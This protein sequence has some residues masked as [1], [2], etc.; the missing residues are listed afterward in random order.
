MFSLVYSAGYGL[1]RYVGVGKVLEGLFHLEFR[2]IG[3]KQNRFILL[4]TIIPLQSVPTP[5]PRGRST[6]PGP[7][8]PEIRR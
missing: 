8:G 4:E 5:P 7:G 1:L 6:T 3:T 2:T